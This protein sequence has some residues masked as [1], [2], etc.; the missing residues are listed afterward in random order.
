MAMYLDYDRKA[1]NHKESN[2]SSG[3]NQRSWSCRKATLLAVLYDKLSLKIP[4][5]TTAAHAYRKKERK[6]EST[7]R[8]I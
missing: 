3:L 2:P 8:F 7:M 1:E 6:K 4:V 5:A